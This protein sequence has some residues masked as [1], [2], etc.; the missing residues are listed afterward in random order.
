MLPPPKC[1]AVMAPHHGSLSGDPK[2]FLDWC[3]AQW[4]LISGSERAKSAAVNEVYGASA[5]E[6]Y[7]T[8]RE[9]ALELRVTPNGR[10]SLARWDG[11]NWERIREA[12]DRREK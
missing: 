3:G 6:V 1:D 11:T 4:V 8:A 7:V 12:A 10:M 9:R 2:T 5:R